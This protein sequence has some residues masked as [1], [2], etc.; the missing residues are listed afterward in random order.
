MRAIKEM[1]CLRVSERAPT[2]WGRNY[3][4]LVGEFPFNVFD[5]TPY[6][7]NQERVPT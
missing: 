6:R 2:R 5:L 3:L 7:V 4:D 1:L